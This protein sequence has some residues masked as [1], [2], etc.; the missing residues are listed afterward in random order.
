M[1]FLEFFSLHEDPFRLIPDPFYF[2]PSCEHK[3]ILESIRYVI[4]H[5]EGFFLV[6][7]EPGTGKTTI[8]KTFLNS[9]KDK[10]KIAMILT[11]R[12]SP[13]EFLLAVMEDLGVRIRSTNKH[14][15]IRTFRDFLIEN[16]LSGKRVIIIVDE[17]Q[18][19][20]QETL[21]ELR[22]LSNMETEKEKLLQIV[23]IGQVE[24]QRMLASDSLKQ[25]NQRITVRTILRPLTRD[26]TINYINYRLVKGRMGLALFEKSAMEM[27][28]KFSKGVPRLINLICSRTMMAAFLDGSMKI[29]KAHVRQAISHVYDTES[30]QTSM[31]LHPKFRYAL[32]AAILLFVSAALAVIVFF[33]F[34]AGNGSQNVAPGKMET[35][36]ELAK[37]MEAERVVGGYNPDLN[38]GEGQIVR[39]APEEILTV[40]VGD[41][42]ARRKKTVAV[43]VKIANIRKLPTLNARITGQALKDTLLEI[44]GEIKDEDGRK[45]YK[46]KTDDSSADGWIVGRLT[47]T[48]N[49]I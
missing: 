42:P 49:K 16:A 33:P 31:T 25:L 22:L 12:L 37:G 41:F 48:A 47:R 29:S 38:K 3:E 7:G 32:L 2:Y 11:P 28:Y 39:A 5:K 43:N 46:V 34:N 8:M 36:V 15:I 27:V 40:N 26:E 19:L 13:E 44:I 24:L 23:L 18:N 35:G 21:E 1:D 9:W 14:N 4:E 20:P 6:T 45:W 10:A 17:A 30:P